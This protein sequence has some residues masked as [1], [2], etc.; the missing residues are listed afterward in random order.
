MDI[1]LEKMKRLGL[2]FGFIAIGTLL[3]YSQGSVLASGDW[4]KF[5]ITKSGIY[6]IDASLL[7]SMGID[8]NSIDPRTIKVYGNGGGGILPQSL[9]EPITS[10]P[11]ENATYKV[12]LEDGSFEEQDFIL[13]FGRGPDH[14]EYEEG[15]WNYTKNIY[16]DTTYYFMTLDGEPGKVIQS[17]PNLGTSFPVVTSF[18]DVMTHE[19]DE[20]NVLESG[21]KWYGDLMSKSS[22]VKTFQFETLNLV[23]S[24]F[25]NLDMMAYLEKSS[26]FEIRYNDIELGKIEV[27]SVRISTYEIKGREMSGY[28][29][30]ISTE[31]PGTLEIN[32]FDPGIPSVMFGY[33]D[34]IV[35]SYRRALRHDGKE[36]IFSGTE[37][38]GNNQSTFHLISETADVN[39]WDISDPA[40]VLRQEG[41][42]DN[43]IF[44]FGAETTSLKKYIS[45]TGNSFEYPEFFGE[46]KNQNIKGLRPR[47]GLIITSKQFQE[48]ASRLSKFHSE[49]DSIDNVVLYVD[50]IYNE[51]SSGMQDI[52]AIRNAIKYF[53]DLNPETFRYVLFLGDASY[54]YKD[55]VRNNTNFVPI[56]ESY[57]SLDPV[58]TYSSEDFFGFMEEFEGEWREGSNPLNH[59]LEIGVGRL[60]VKTIEE[61]AEIVDKIIRYSTSPRLAGNWKNEV[62]YVVDDGDRNIHVADAE[63]LANYLRDNE[64]QLS[65]NKLYIDA[66]DQEIIKSNQRSAAVKQNLENAIEEGTFLINYLGHGSEARWAEE[67]IFEYT[68]FDGLKNKYKLP[69]F[70]T[71]TCEFG[72]YDDPLIDLTAGVSGAEKLL[73]NPDGGAIALLT[74][75]R[76]VFAFSNFF[77]NAAFHTFFFKKDLRLGDVVR[78]TKNNS[79]SGVRNRNFSLLGDPM[80]RLALPQYDA[81]I[82]EI[83]GDDIVQFSNDTLSALEQVRLSGVITDLNGNLV[84]TFNGTILVS[85]FDR[86]TTRKTKGQESS[87]FTYTVRE[88]RLFNGEAS[89]VNGQFS[90]DFIL[91]KNISYRFEKG[92][93]TLYA[94]NQDRDLDASGFTSNIL[95]G[96]S[97]GDLNAD[98]DP[99][100]VNMYFN[101]P[102]F[103]SGGVIGSNSLFIAD[104]E[105]E[106]GINTSGIGI[107]QNAELII[108]DTLTYILNNY[109][110]ADIGTYKTGRIVF[111]LRG[112]APGSYK[113]ELKI[114]DVYNNSSTNSVD[115]MVSDQPE[116]QLFN[117]IN[118]PNPANEY[119][120]FQFEHDR[121]GE[122]LDVTIEIF[123]M[124][125]A[126]V[127]YEVYRLE[128]VDKR[129]TPIR[130]NLPA[131]KFGEGLYFYRLTVDSDL[132]NASGQELKKLLIIK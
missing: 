35:F 41:E 86:E 62:T 19:S 61:A 102:S 91:P 118:Y 18:K 65:I 117:V 50:E 120:D 106:S 55:R 32:L 7:S 107:S 97:G 20:Y 14:L 49:H 2:V 88:N 82:T 67:T 121:V 99:P 28:F 15:W 60:P 95:I 16:S 69:V 17:S 46:I 83:N 110:T 90:I 115:F 105:D 114:W 92:K 64:G 24:I 63:D 58:A 12:G 132:D 93:I 3:C 130:V 103:S 8:P 42:Y 53:Y 31:G 11:I 129:I 98:N 56:Y 123:N 30:F 39:V 21:R 38:L 79:L 122:E 10:D 74:T 119:T 48:E 128:D 101:D 104:I 85:V 5:G 76:P 44:K 94:E 127:F 43:G 66:F 89:V 57:N 33:V 23:D 78:L 59:T 9:S 29:K 96:G 37:S 116:I 100:T 25:L 1:V 13:F 126:K 26:Y 40:N 87:P 109:Y 84:D 80:M 108:N 75:T 51:F 22:N 73:L 27:D 52:T 112:L 113:A 71:A 54:D 81:S 131:G 34:R 47:D 45:F 124:R 70:L 4:Y 77:V 72:R 111:P 68:D 6:K 36:M 125:G